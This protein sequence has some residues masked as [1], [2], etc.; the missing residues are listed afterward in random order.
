[1][2]RTIQIG[3]KYKP[4]MDYYS[5]QFDKEEF[6]VFI[7]KLLIAYKKMKD[8]NIDLI[9][10]SELIEPYDVDIIDLIK[11]ITENTSLSNITPSMDGI[12]ITQTS[13]SDD[14]QE[15][16]ETQDSKIIKMGNKH[17]ELNN[18][19]GKETQSNHTDKIS[20]N[21][22]LNLGIDLSQ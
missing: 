18:N 4:L 19:N 2:Q 11:L 20:N 12:V 15:V 6:N 5:E 17:R 13:D 3:D 22:I 14:K 7:T 8:K 9:T 1:M 10:F 21:P 16:L